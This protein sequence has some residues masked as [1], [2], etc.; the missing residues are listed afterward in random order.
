MV[1]EVLKGAERLDL[2][3]RYVAAGCLYQTVW[4]V[5]DGHPPERGISDYDLIYSTRLI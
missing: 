4:N 5:L 2:P 1:R 3:D